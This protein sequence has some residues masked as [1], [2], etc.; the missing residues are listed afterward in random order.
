M[1][2]E[3]IVS[4]A[5]LVEKASVDEFYLDMTGME[6]LWNFFLCSKAPKNDY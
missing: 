1:V 2:T 6:K 3:V 4:N 5:P